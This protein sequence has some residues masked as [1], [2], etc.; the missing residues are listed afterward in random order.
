LTACVDLSAWPLKSHHGFKRVLVR[1]EFTKWI[2]QTCSGFGPVCCAGTQGCFSAVLGGCVGAVEL[3]AD[4]AP[5]WKVLETPR[6]TVVSQISEKETR[7]WAEEFNQFID[8]LKG[9]LPVDERL[10]PRLTVI[11][12]SREKDFNAYRPVGENG[13]VLD[14]VTGFFSRQETWSVAAMSD[15]FEDESMRRSMFQEGVYWFVSADQR[16]YPMWFDVGVAGLFST[17][18]FRENK[19]QWGQPI[20]AHVRSLNR[21]KLIPLQQLLSVSRSNKLFNDED[22]AGLFYAESWAFVHY[23]MFGQRKD[24][25]GSLND[26][27]TASMGGLSNEDALKKAFGVDFAAMESALDAYLSGGKYRVYSQPASPTAKITTPFEPASP[28]LVQVALAKLAYGSNH[29]DMAKKHAEEAVRLDPGYAAGYTMLAWVR[30]D[31]E[32]AD[33]F[34]EAADKAVQLGAGSQDADALWLL[35]MARSKKARALGGVPSGEARQIANLLERAINLFPAQK[36]AYLNLGSILSQVDQPNEQDA[37][38]LEQGRA[39]FP[40]ELLFLFGQAQLLRKKG[41]KEEALK[42]LQAVLD[43]PGQLSGQQREQLEKQKTSWDVSDTLDQLKELGTQKKYKEAVVLLDALLA[44]GTTLESRAIVQQARRDM[45]ALATLQ[46]ASVARK[47]GQKAEA[48]RLYQ[49]I[50]DMERIPAQLRGQAQQA[51]QRLNNQPAATAPAE[52]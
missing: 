33:G 5:Q 38:F 10:L 44:R 37:L 14:W 2:G 39:L 13:K 18:D 8:A 30:R 25:Q 41:N 52:K 32:S 20:E 11:F 4:A 40:D 45:C 24:R 43:Q 34:F 17:F 42:L 9:V 47:A 1:D 22:R 36:S 12:F 6:F 7:A 26:F 29:R 27:L 31:E 21:Q 46:E 50:L 49:S 35:A 19:V 51:L 28:A 48:A 15:R 16:R 23:L 3:A